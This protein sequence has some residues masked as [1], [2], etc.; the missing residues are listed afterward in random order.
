MKAAVFYGPGDLRIEQRAEPQPGP[1]QVL[2]RVAACGIC[3]TDRHIYHGEFDTTPPVI[4]GH[5]YAGEIVALGAG[6]HDLAVGDQVTVD[7]NMS[8]GVCRSC[9]RGETHLCEHLAALGV[10][11][12][13]G[14]A[15]LCVAPRAQCFRLPESVT[16]LEGAM[17]EPLACCL[18]GI[19][20]AEVRAGDLVA[21]IGGG[22]IGQMLAQ[23][24][25]LRGAG[26]VVVSDPVAARREMAARLGADA[27]IDPRETDPLAPGGL[28]EGGADVVIEAVGHPATNRQ[29]LEWAARG[30]TVLWFGVTPPGQTVA[31]EPNLI[32]ERELTIRGALVNPYTHAPALALLGSGRVQ[33]RPLITRTISLDEL[34]AAL[35]AGPGD[36][37]KTVVVPR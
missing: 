24:A 17:T 30:G 12:D 37:V 29:A 31:V 13:G 32:F 33:V 9:R 20:L 16:P 35:E 1:G 5:E 36:D 22:A 19:D 26:R 8:C 4:T 14:F 6:V 23:L 25:R 34:P 21:V 18:H 11:V 10:D 3:G 28:L 15:E 2:I 7:P 27:V